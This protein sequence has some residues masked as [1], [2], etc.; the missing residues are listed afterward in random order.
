MYKRQQANLQQ[1]LGYVLDGMVTQG[2]LSPADRAAT[3]MPPIQAKAPARMLTGSTGYVVTSVRKEL[4]DKL[5]LT[6]E[7]IDTGGLRVTTT[8]DK[9]S[10]DAA[11][12]AVEKNLP[13]K[14]DVATV[15]ALSLIHI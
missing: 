11:V 2:W 6:D 3:G 14:G 7:Q 15:Y 8:I 1:R 5:K 4:R 9:R 12:T 13:V 10:Q